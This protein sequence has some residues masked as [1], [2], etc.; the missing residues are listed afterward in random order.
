[1]KNLNQESKR[2]RIRQ[3]HCNHPW[4]LSSG[5]LFV[6]HV[7][8]KPQELSWWD[9]VGFIL[10][11]RRV[12]VW[13]VH[14]RMKYADAIEDTAWAEA[15]EPPNSIN[16]IFDSRL[17]TK[18]Y[19]SQ[20][21]ARKKTIAYR[22]PPKASDTAEYFSRLEIIQNRIEAEGIDITV[23]PSIGIKTFDW[24]VG[25]DLCLPHEIQ[26]ENDLIPLAD[27]ARR[28]LMGQYSLALT[29]SI[30]DD[31][32]YDKKQW[33]AEAKARQRDRHK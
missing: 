20:G 5:G 14:P 22:A 24:C 26:N 33:L 12:M 1:M 23:R 28:A 7:Y 6:P 21:R 25:I 31:Y 15:G 9:D 17:C 3:Y 19:K 16:D 29:G 4:R 8:P 27:I 2:R 13:W 32:R 30:P 18:H 11:G 10:N